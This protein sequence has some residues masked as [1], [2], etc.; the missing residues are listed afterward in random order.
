M[1]IFIWIVQLCLFVY[2]AWMPV[3]LGIQALHLHQEGK[4]Y[5][6]GALM[7]FAWACNM[8]FILLFK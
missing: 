5:W 1:D 4:I 3:S 7:L 6:A 2:A 8:F